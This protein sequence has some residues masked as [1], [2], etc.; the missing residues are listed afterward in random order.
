MFLPGDLQYPFAFQLPKQD[1]PPSVQFKRCHV[2]DLEAVRAAVDYAVDAALVVE[3]FTVADATASTAFTVKQPIA[4]SVDDG[5]PVAAQQQDAPVKVLGLFKSGLCSVSVELPSDVLNGGSTVEA[6]ASLAFHTPQRLKYVKLAL[7]QDATI[8]R[9]GKRF[10]KRLKH[11]SRAVSS[12][13]FDP[14]AL[15]LGVSPDAAVGSQTKASLQLPLTPL[16]KP[17]CDALVATLSSH[18]LTVQYH[19]R[20]ECH[21]AMARTVRVCVPVT[22]VGE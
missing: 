17:K 21:F 8:D 10:Q 11:G 14:A 6:H 20:V 18:Y 15:G 3:A 16:D 7:H 19:V 2:D 1:L 4:R 9:H 12:R 5:E 22:V 13:R